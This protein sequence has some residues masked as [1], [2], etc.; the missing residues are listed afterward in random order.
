[1]KK[2][3]IGQNPMD[4]LFSHNDLDFGSILAVTKA[5]APS[6]LQIRTQDINPSQIGD[7]V[8]SVLDQFKEHLLKGT[9][10]SINK[11]KSRAR[12]LPIKE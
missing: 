10:I 8:I 3:L 12:I 1:M 6:V 2:S 4:I 7:L 5:R 11:E 9:L